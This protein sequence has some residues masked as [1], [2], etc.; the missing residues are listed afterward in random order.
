MA[1]YPLNYGMYGSYYG[2]YNYYYPQAYS[3]G[4]YTS[5]KTYYIESN[6]YDLEQDQLLWS[7]QSDAY[8]P[9][10]LDKWFDRYSYDLL[11]ELKK[12]GLI[13]K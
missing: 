3:P 11:N 2:Y 5:N 10:S 4:Y 6:F 13:A 7:F 9:S 8:N 12:E 1:Y